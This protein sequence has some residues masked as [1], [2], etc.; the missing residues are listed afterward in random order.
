M[1]FDLMKPPEGKVEPPPNQPSL[2]T[3]G[4]TAGGIPKSCELV[5]WFVWKSETGPFKAPGFY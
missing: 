1:P 4:L 3:S 2:D 5:V